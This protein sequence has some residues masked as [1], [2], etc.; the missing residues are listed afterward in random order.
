MKFKK[1][2]SLFLAFFLLVS[3]SGFAFNVH[4]CEGKIA[5]VYSVFNVEEICEM[6]ASSAE[7]ACCAK[8]TEVSHQKCCSNK[9]V[10]LQDKTDTEIVKSFSFQIAVPFLQNNQKPVV[11]APFSVFKSSLITTY[12][13]EANAPPLFKLY[14]QY[15]FYA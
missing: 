13:C 1:H 10:D 14:S 11:F 9:V 2:M 12:F 6:A 3:N 7:K 8:E 15:L 4:F 5:S